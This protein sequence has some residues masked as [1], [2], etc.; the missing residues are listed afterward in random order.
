[1]KWRNNIQL[2]KCT[3]MELEQ[4]KFNLNGSTWI[5][6]DFPIFHL[7]YTIAIFFVNKLLMQKTCKTLNNTMKNYFT[8]EKFVCLIILVGMEMLADTN[9][10]LW[11][12]LVETLHFSDCETF[13]NK[14]AQ[15]NKKTQNIT[16]NSIPLEILPITK[17]QKKNWQVRSNQTN[18]L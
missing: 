3:L 14:N 12:F 5:N 1:M 13:R 8:R 18:K 6:T 15:K 16:F 4:L 9:L 11:I 10:M 7:R 17:Q 2:P